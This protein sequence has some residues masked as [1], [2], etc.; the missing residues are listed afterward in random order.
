MIRGRE[1]GPGE[2]TLVTRFRVATP[3]YFETMGIPI[4]RGRGIE[5]T[6]T[7]QAPKIAVVD[8]TLARRFWPDGNALGQHVRI[9]DAKT[10]NPWLTIVGVVPSAK[11]G[12]VTEE[13][14]RYVYLPFAQ[15]FWSSMDVV[16]H[17]ASRPQA[18]SEAIRHEVQALDGTLPFYEVHTLESAIA[19]SL[20]T[21]RLTERLL[22]AFALAALL[23]AAVGV[24]GVMALNVS[25]RVHEFGIRLAL[26]AAPRDLLRLV[27]GQGM[28]LL[29]IG[30]AIGLLGAVGLARFLSSLLYN[31]KPQDPATFGAVAAVLGVVALCA[32]YLPARRATRTD[33]LT[34]LRDE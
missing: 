31:V 15:N 11:H 24:Y 4:L 28:R 19:R 25:H 33:P 13:A 17:A 18:L 12:D 16:V 9:G 30:L 1:P 6:D 26:G 7:A 32:C 10:K 5:E 3:G 8:E 14:N 23:L 20:G 21:R 22:L 34:A 29:L 2:P 27:L